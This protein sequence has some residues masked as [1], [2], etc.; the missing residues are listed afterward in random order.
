MNK[1]MRFGAYGVYEKWGKVLLSQKKSGPFVGAWCLPGGAIEFGE[2]PEIT[3]KREFLEEVCLE[4]GKWEFKSIVTALGDYDEASQ[5]PSLHQTGV[6]FSVLDA[7]EVPDRVPEEV[8]AW[9]DLK[10]LAG[11]HLTPLSRTVFQVESI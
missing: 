8:S 3:L 6:I 5:E 7:K 2:T 10:S 11:V 9:F 4:I 1:R